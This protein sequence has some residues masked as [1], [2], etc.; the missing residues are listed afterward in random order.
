MEVERV[1][2]LRL[3]PVDLER[4]LIFSKREPQT[5]LKTDERATRLE[6][7][8]EGNSP[9]NQ[10]VGMKTGFSSE[11]PNSTSRSSAAAGRSRACP[12]PAAEL[13]RCYF[14]DD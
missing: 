1:L 5:I 6:L 3:E 11:A 2:H 13:L 12:R 7:G 8:C 4:G 9:P 10:P 14:P